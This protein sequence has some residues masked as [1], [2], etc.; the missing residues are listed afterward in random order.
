M[1]CPQ[2]WPNPRALA[3]NA[4][5]PDPEPLRL[6][7]QWE[8]ELEM[9]GGKLSVLSTQPRHFKQPVVTARRFGRYAI[10]LWIGKELVDRVRFD[11]PGLAPESPEPPPD[12]RKPLFGPPNF[13]RGVEV[14]QRVL[15]P[16]APRARQARLIDRATGEISPLEWPP[17]PSAA[18]KP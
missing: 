9:K 14:R 7:D 18:P 11:L 5:P 4:E 1:T 10:E 6:A 2:A 12:K 16:A 17:V 8:Y 13:A 15:V 3:E